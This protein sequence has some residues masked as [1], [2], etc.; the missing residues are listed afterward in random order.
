MAG[1]DSSQDDSTISGQSPAVIL[2][3]PQLGENIGACARAMMNCGLMEMR[4]VDPRD[5]WPNEAA[6]AMSSGAHEILERAKIYETTVE[7]TADLNLVLAS[8]AR[9]RDMVKDQM[10]AKEAAVSLKSHISGGGKAGVLFGAERSGLTNEDVVLADAIIQ[11]PLNPAFSSLNLGQ[12]VLLI[13]YEWFQLGQDVSG[14]LRMGKEEPATVQEKEFFFNRLEDELDQ[15]EFFRPTELAPSIKQNLR[16]M[17]GRARMTGQEVRTL[18]GVLK[19][20]V[21]GRLSAKN[22]L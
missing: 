10:T 4:V 18:H 5:G 16:N 19:A 3:R 20:L 22:R 17:F 11:V 13:A 6:V 7:A 9:I 8:T 14:E 1:T 15:A 2:V 12:A 21:K